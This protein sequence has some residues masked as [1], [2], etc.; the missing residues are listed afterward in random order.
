M[1]S[2][3]LPKLTDLEI[4]LKIRIGNPSVFT[5]TRNGGPS[6][7]GLVPLRQHVVQLLRR[8]SNAKV[9]IPPFSVGISSDDQRLIFRGTLLVL[10]YIPRKYNTA[11]KRKD[12]PQR[13]RTEDTPELSQLLGPPESRQVLGGDDLRFCLDQGGLED[14][15]INVLRSEGTG[16]FR[17]AV[18]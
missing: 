8:L 10:E 2:R 12:L 18:P 16:R 4:S 13:L 17:N 3:N 11:D 5:P 14:T 9:E 1:A 6:L 15:F 7:P